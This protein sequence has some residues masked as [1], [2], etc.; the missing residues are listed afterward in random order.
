EIA[1]SEVKKIAKYV[2]FLGDPYFRRGWESYSLALAEHDHAIRHIYDL[3]DAA[4]K[5]LGN[6][7]KLL[8]I[9]DDEWSRFGKVLNNQPVKGGRHNGMQPE[10]MRPLTEEERTFLLRFA[11]K[12]LYAFGNF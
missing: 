4:K 9:S 11:E 3:R 1:K 5:R 10:P 6:A 12:L 2:R 8:G 7:Q